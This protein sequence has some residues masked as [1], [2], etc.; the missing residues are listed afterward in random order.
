MCL[1]NNTKGAAETINIALKNLNM[2]D[3][4]ILC[5]DGDNFYYQI[6]II[7]LWNHKNIVFTFYDLSDKEIYSYIKIN[8]NNIID[9]T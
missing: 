8:N 2:P 9:I 3:E 5:L 1:D 7:K 4:P 6:D